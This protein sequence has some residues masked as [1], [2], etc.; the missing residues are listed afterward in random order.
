MIAGRVTEDGQPIIQ[1]SVVGRSWEALIDTGFNG[2]LELP[3]ALQAQF[4]ARFRGRQ[5][6]LLAGGQR[7]E[8]DTYTWNFRLTVEP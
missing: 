2:D 6:W 8:S 3:N 1:V 5:P 7:I 4:N